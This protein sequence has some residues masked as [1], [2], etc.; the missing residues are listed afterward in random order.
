MKKINVLI[1][2]DHQMI[3]NGIR[4]M[5]DSQQNKYGS[6][7]VDEANTVD[8]ALKKT[9]TTNYDIIIMD[10]QLPLLTG[11][12]ITKQ[13]LAEKP[14]S[15]IVGMSVFNDGAYLKA[16]LDAG[17]SSYFLKNIGP[18]ELNLLLECA[19][20]GVKYYPVDV[21]KIFQENL[22]KSNKTTSSGNDVSA[23]SIKAIG[24]G[25]IHLTKR[26]KQVLYHLAK[27]R[28]S[29]E[30]AKIFDKKKGTIDGVRANLLRK[31]NEKRIAAVVKIAIELRLI[32]LK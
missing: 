8:I 14:G 29:V 21:Q 6:Y 28:T 2:D 12:Q 4:M 7:N 13:I 26:E 20:S 5:L 17:V 30:I 23:A 19:L 25:E 32:N 16:M 9:Q 18:T 27:K 10:Y 22:E 3:I 11:A 15:K 31:F 24:N 1:V